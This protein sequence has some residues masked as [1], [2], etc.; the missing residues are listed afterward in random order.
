MK[1][2]VIMLVF[3]VAVLAQLLV[4]ASMI[5]KRETTLRE[6]KVFKFRTAPVDPFDAFRGRYVALSYEEES[7][8]IPVPAEWNI[9]RDQNVFAVIEDGD[10]G[11]A[12]I[13][14]IDVK[15]PDVEDYFPVV[16]QYT[17]ETNVTVFFR[18][19]RFYMDEFKAPQA[20]AAYREGMQDT[21]RSVYVTMRVKDGF[22]VVENLFIDDLP[23]RDY[24]ETPR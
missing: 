20:E 19:K 9:Q 21:N 7:R 12:R 1:R 6:G 2:P 10:D 15:R 14:R 16:A 4:P 8:D 18:E 23:M 13:A 5:A 22:G 11:F 17:S 3:A 24:L